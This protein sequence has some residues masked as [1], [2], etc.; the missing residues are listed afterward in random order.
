MKLINFD[1]FFSVFPPNFHSE[2][3]VT[4][5]NATPTGSFVRAACDFVCAKGDRLLIE[6]SF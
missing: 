1:R 4:S 3:L 2:S 6:S 5:L